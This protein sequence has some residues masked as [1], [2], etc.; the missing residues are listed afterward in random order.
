[1]TEGAATHDHEDHDH[2]H[3][4]HGTTTTATTTRR[5]PRPRRSRPRP[6]GRARR[7]HEHEDDGHE[8]DHGDGHDHGHGELA[9]VRL[10]V[11]SLDGPEAIVIDAADGD[12]VGRFTLPGLGRVY[13]LPN[14]QLAGVTHRDANRV[15]FVHSGLTAIDHGD[16]MDLVV[17]SPY[18]LQTVNLGPQP[19]HFFAMGHD[20]AVYND[21]DGSMVWLDARLLG[22]SL[23]VAA[24][25]ASRPT[26]ARWRSSTATSS[27]AASVRRRCG[28]T[29]AT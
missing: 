3:D 15:S 16:H 13:Q 9:G 10:L 25:M 23:D 14:P 1:M 21:G 28:S 19:T 29:T 8:H 17:G 12:V 27:A 22:I 18:V 7:R 24:S 4:D 20:I 11:A 6:R 5:R 2:D 26:T